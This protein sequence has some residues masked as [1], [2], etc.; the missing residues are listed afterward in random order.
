MIPSSSVTYRRDLGQ[1]VLEASIAQPFVMKYVLP[2]IPV[3]QR[4]D[5]FK[6]IT[7]GGPLHLPDTDW[8][9]RGAPKEYEAA[10]DE[11]SYSC[12]KHGLDVPLSDT[13]QAELEDSFPIQMMAA[14]MGL[15][16]LLMREEYDGAAALFNTTTFPLSGT[17]GVSVSTPWATTASA[18]PIKDVQTG[19]NVIRKKC[20]M[21]ATSLL[22]P[23][24]TLLNLSRCADVTDRVKYVDP[25]ITN[26]VLQNSALAA[27]LGVQRIYVAGGVYNSANEGQTV[28]GADIWDP[29]MAL[30]FVETP[31]HRN[32]VTGN[33]EPVPMTE[34]S[35]L[36]RTFVWTGEVQG[37]LDAYPV[38]D[39]NA[40]ETK[41]RVKRFRDQKIFSTR[42][43]Y[44]LGNLD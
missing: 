13:Q 35:T 12:K 37:P 14:Q 27:A 23:F 39:A 8:S 10:L 1:A 36:G 19:V 20:G 31:Q 18:T 44:L 34:M 22:I 9:R 30:L 4:V 41:F 26:G 38:R 3:G 40:E 24:P 29:D 16:G 5:N 43:A 28:S 32:P 7:A 11:D 2:D 6:K 21:V 15:N 42:F 33:L 17:T 25:V